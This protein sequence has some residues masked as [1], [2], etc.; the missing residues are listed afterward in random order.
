[1]MKLLTILLS[2]M[3]ILSGVTPG[4]VNAPAAT[5][6]ADVVED[7]LQPTEAD[8]IVLDGS[9]S[10]LEAMLP[11]AE[12]YVLNC[13]L[14]SWAEDGEAFLAMGTDGVYYNVMLNEDTL[15]YLT[16]SLF[17]G[18]WIQVAYDGKMTRAIPAGINAMAIVQCYTMGMVTEAGDGYL[19]LALEEGSAIVNRVDE[20]PFSEGEGVTVFFDGSYTQE[21]EVFHIDSFGNLPDG[22]WGEITEINDDGFVMNCEGEEYV[23]ALTPDTLMMPFV[24]E[25]MQPAELVEG[26][27]VN[28]VTTGTMTMSIPAHVTAAQ[29]LVWVAEE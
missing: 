15:V 19:K 17:E 18:D 4:A 22:L 24:Y 9:V 12:Y 1:M 23:V 29:V 26:M 28:V 11:D 16:D 21:D 5:V 3:M 6:P 20:Y 27:S 13:Q 14:L 7:T 25:T 8:A 2:A 10:Y